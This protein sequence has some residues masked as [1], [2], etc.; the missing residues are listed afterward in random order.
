MK[1]SVLIGGAAILLAVAAFA[2]WPHAPNTEPRAREMA[3]T[4]FEHLC[5]DSHLNTLD[6]QG[7]IPTTVDGAQFAYEW[8]SIRPGLRTVLVSVASDGGS[9]VALYRRMSC[10]GH[11]K[12]KSA[13]LVKLG[14]SDH[15][16]KLHALLTKHSSLD[17]E[18]FEELG[19]AG[20]WLDV[21]VALLQSEKAASKLQTN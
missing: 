20:K 12:V 1:R 7:P 2:L 17:V 19:A 18:L 6:Y 5:R 9:L 11:P 4:R 14:K 21:P 10:A 13:F 8:R 15:E 3:Q 16:A